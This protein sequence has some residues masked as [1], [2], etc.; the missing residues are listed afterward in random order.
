MLAEARGVRK[1]GC[2]WSHRPGGPRLQDDPRWTSAG[3]RSRKTSQDHIQEFGLS[4]VL[5][6]ATL[7]SL[8]AMD[9]VRPR[10]KAGNAAA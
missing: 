3:A 8:K 10:V 9:W 6:K 5:G 7:T 1:W 2:G 4:L